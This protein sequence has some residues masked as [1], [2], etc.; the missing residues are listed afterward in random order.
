MYKIVATDAAE[1]DLSSIRD[2]LLD[3]F[4]NPLAVDNLFDAIRH[5]YET[6]ADDPYVFEA[7]ADSRLRR[8][9]YRKCLV[10]AYLFIYRVEETGDG[11]GIV[12]V[13]RY[14][15]GSQ[16]YVSQL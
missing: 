15:H 12:H 1:K 11:D 2:Y 3:E 9:G 13:I 16:N 4:C 10:K 5:A 6:L 14:F 8:K 7:C